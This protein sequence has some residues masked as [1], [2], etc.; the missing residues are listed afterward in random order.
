[1]YART[2]ARSAPYSMVLVS[3]RGLVVCEMQILLTSDLSKT[4]EQN[5]LGR[6]ARAPAYLHFERDHVLSL[7]YLTR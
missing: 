4:T 6:H 1:M 7:H 2:F 3:L 5:N